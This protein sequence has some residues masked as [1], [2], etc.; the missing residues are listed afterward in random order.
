[1]AVGEVVVTFGNPYDFTIAGF[2]APAPFAF[3]VLVEFPLIIVSCH[4]FSS[5]GFTNMNRRFRFSSALGERKTGTF[6]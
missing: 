3:G 4:I 1:M 5:I 6:G 2:P